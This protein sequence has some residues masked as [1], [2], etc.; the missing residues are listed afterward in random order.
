MESWPSREQE[1]TDCLTP[2]LLSDS[3]MPFDRMIKPVN[4]AAVWRLGMNPPPSFDA[5]NN[6]KRH[7]AKGPQV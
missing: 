7:V 5:F 6:A 1:A 3:T 2:R 4:V